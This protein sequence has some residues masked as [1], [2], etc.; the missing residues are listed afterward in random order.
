[1][2]LHFRKRTP[3]P[4]GPGSRAL[5]PAA[6]AALLLGWPAEPLAAEDSLK[7]YQSPYY[8]IHTDLDIDA[9][10]EAAVRTMAMAEE[11]HRRTRGFSGVIRSKLPFY[12]YRRAE[13]YHRAGGPAGSVG[14]FT[15]GRLMALAGER[16]GKRT[17]HTLQHEGFHQFAYAVIGGHIPSGSTRVW[18]STSARPSSP[19]TGSSRGLSRRPGWP[20]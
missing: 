7:T 10:R 15:G 18:L 14:A 9:A 2:R 13:D 5:L 4:Q 1:M 6:C 12:L 19:A 17:W 11:Y 8:V 3:R 16:P 20:G